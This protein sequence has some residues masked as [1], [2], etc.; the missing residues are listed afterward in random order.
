MSSTN[1]FQASTRRGAAFEAI[2][3]NPNQKITLSCN[4]GQKADKIRWYFLRSAAHEEVFAYDSKLIPYDGYVGECSLEKQYCNL[5]IPNATIE[6]AGRYR[7]EH[8]VNG[9][10][11]V[12][13]CVFEL[14]LGG[15]CLEPLELL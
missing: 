12:Q 9:K 15:L 7:L 1:F 3:A 13:D 4:F 8:G 2:F 11:R 6:F 10:E 14:I 5:I